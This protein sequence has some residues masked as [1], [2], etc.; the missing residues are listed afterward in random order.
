M[1]C[2]GD[3]SG[4]YV[5]V[6]FRTHVRICGDSCGIYARIHMGHYEA[7]YVGWMGELMWDR[8]GDERGDYR[9]N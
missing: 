2:R 3:I 8:Y 1:S 9:W 4:M 6:D 7:I 5:C